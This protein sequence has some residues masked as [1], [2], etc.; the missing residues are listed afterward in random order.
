LLKTRHRISVL[1]LELPAFLRSDTLEKCETEKR[2]KMSGAP[3]LR[4]RQEFLPS[5][6]ELPTF[7]R[8]DTT[9]K[10]ETKSRLN[11]RKLRGTPNEGG[12]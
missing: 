11:E 1:A 2:K 6:L 3:L 4:K 8:L 10:H 9:E 7:L 12:K 5:A